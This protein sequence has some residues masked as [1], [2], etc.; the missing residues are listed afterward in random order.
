MEGQVKFFDHKRHFGFLRLLD[1]SGD[2]VSEHF[3]SGNDCIDGLPAK[4][5][6]VQFLL[7][8]PPSRARRRELIAVEVARIADSDTVALAREDLEKLSADEELAH[9]LLSIEK[10]RLGVRHLLPLR[11]HGC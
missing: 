4:G 1:E 2:V 7:D 8:D 10:R 9:A 5:D 3:F 11:G 6:R